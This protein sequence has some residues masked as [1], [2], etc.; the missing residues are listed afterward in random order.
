MTKWNAPLEYNHRLWICSD[1]R[2]YDFYIDNADCI[3]HFNVP[4]KKEIFSIR[5]SVFQDSS[6]T[7]IVSIFN[8]TTYNF[9]FFFTLKCINN[10]LFFVNIFYLN[11]KNNNI[12][13]S[14]WL[15][16]MHY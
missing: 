6:N 3:I 10:I 15:Y 8:L 9:F 5:F 7:L 1:I 14:L 16:A 12:R 13:Y 4:L 11:V 2:L